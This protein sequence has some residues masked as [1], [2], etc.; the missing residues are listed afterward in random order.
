VFENRVLWRIFELMGEYVAGGWRTLINAHV[1]LANTMGLKII[2]IM[3]K[4]G[5][6][7]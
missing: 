2:I 4:S 1:Q 3:L 6:M 7:K 5:R